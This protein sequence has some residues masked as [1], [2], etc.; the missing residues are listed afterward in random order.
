MTYPHERP[1]APP[2]PLPDR[3]HHQ[4]PEPNWALDLLFGSYLASRQLDSRLARANNWYPSSS[5]GDG[6]PRAVVSCE[7]NITSGF[8]QA[9]LMVDVGAASALRWQSPHGD[10]GDAV[11]MVF[12]RGEP[13]GGVVVEG[14]MCALAAADLGYL[15]VALLG[16]TPSQHVWVNVLT[17]LVGFNIVAVADR[18]RPDLAARWVAPLSNAGPTRLVVPTLAKDLADHTIEQRRQLLG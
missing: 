14:P 3:I 1:A 10:R 16:A 2:R 6:L 8:W 4:R 15:G 11:A 18:D 7:G 13:L 12:P 17:T 5:A 9:R